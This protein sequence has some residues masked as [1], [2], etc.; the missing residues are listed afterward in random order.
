MKI[1]NN[2]SD[3]KKAKTQVNCTC[4]DD[5]AKIIEM[6]KTN[7][8]GFYTFS[9]PHTKSRIFVLKRHYRVEKEEML[10]ILKEEQLEATKVTFLM[11][12]VD[13][14]IYLVHFDGEMNI[15][16]LQHQHKDL[17]GLIITWEKFD[18]RSKRLTQCHRCQLWGH[19]AS[20]CER[21]RRCVKCLSSHEPGQCARTN[22]EAD[23]DPECVNCKGKHPANSPTCSVYKKYAERIQQHRRRQ[24]APTSV[25]K[26]ATVRQALPFETAPN[27]NK[28]PSL[29]QRIS[30]IQTASYANTVSKAPNDSAAD[31][32]SSCSQSR[33]LNLGNLHEQFAA[34]P[35]IDK[36]MEIFSKLIADLSATTDHY[37]RIRLLMPITHPQY[38]C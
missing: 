27:V 36:T 18:L 21:Q 15:N 31:E 24:P 1:I 22:R 32:S 2:D 37:A 3:S 26:P 25:S 10:Q 35:E 6:L 34:I 19:S 12:H 30:Q 14:P 11:D 13:R 9:E 29:A 33:K 17:Q 8:I 5:K 20:N 4:L 28:F 7:K 38:V 23:G 16:I